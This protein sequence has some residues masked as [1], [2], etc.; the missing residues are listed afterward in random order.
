MA[1]LS[2]E[3]G[4]TFSGDGLDIAALRKRRAGVEMNFAAGI[5]LPDDVVQGV[6]DEYLTE[7]IN[8][9][10]ALKADQGL[11]ARTVSADDAVG[12]SK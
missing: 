10:A 2:S 3:R 5:G 7:R 1:E 9:H 12:N 4:S 8:S 6:C 11:R